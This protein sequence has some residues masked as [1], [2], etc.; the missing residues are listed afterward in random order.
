MYLLE[1]WFDTNLTG[2]SES[3]NGGRVGSD[4]LDFVMSLYIKRWKKNMGEMLMEKDQEKF[5]YKKFKY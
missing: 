2:P 3:G 1:N 5:V 4:W